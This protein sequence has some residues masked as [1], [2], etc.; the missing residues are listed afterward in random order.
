MYDETEAGKQKRRP[1]S[2]KQ[3][4]NFALCERGIGMHAGGYMRVIVVEV[5]TFV[6]CSKRQTSA[7]TTIRF[8]KQKQ[9]KNKQKKKQSHAFDNFVYTWKFGQITITWLSLKLSFVL[10]AMLDPLIMD[11]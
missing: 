5:W 7:V 1:L 4:L 9:N 6:F 3:L 11:Q 8:C 2:R 10:N